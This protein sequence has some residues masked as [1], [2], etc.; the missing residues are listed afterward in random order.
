MRAL[1][2][3]TDTHSSNKL[4]QDG[5]QSKQATIRHRVSSS[6]TGRTPIVTYCL[7]VEQNACS[8]ITLATDIALEVVI[9]HCQDLL[10]PLM[11]SPRMPDDTLY[12]VFEEDFEFSDSVADKARRAA[13]AS[14]SAAPSSSAPA[15]EQPAKRLRAPPLRKDAPLPPSCRSPDWKSTFANDLAILCT[16]AA[17][18]KVGD[19]VWLGY[20]PDNY[21][22]NPLKSSGGPNPKC[23]T[24]AVAVTKKGA[25]LMLQEFQGPG[26]QP[27]DIDVWFLAW[28]SKLAASGGNVSFV[29]PPVGGFWAHETECCP[30]QENVRQ[31]FWHTRWACQGTRPSHDPQRRPKQIRLYKP[32][33]KGESSVATELQEDDFLNNDVFS[34]KTMVSPLLGP[35]APTTGRQVRAARR[36]VSVQTNFRRF[37]DTEAE[38]CNAAEKP[39]SRLAVV[40]F[41]S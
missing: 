20:Q 28:C 5:K 25:E 32:W 16:A 19:F 36:A 18:V 37:V 24:Q 9:N 29:W 41:R 22:G 6:A 7:V 40:I 4:L 8:V 35:A 10:C 2:R 14:A 1:R 17:R 39:K 26:K 31:N 34:W 23:G 11:T 30:D 15:E 21:W 27:K 33:G 38:A 12:F 13:D 3:T